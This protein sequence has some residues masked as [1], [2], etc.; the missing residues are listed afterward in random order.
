MPAQ[1]APDTNATF[2]ERRTRISPS[3]HTSDDTTHTREARSPATPADFRRPASGL[4]TLTEAKTRRYPEAIIHCNQGG[5]M[6][7]LVGY[8][9]A[10]GSTTGIAERIGAKFEQEGLSATVCPVS[11]IGAVNDYDAVVLGSAIHNQRWLPEAAALVRRESSTLAAVPV[12][13]FSV[14]S[15]GAQTSVFTPVVDRVIRKMSKETKEMAEFRGLLHARGHH[16]FAGAI[17]PGYY[18]LIGRL[19]MKLFGGRYGDHRDWAEVDAWAE[20]IAL[21]LRT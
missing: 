7:V 21:E 13:L 8:A 14:S 19:F 10:H 9:T 11:Q 4:L 18:P 2:S 5:A 17:E 20:G 3:A 15:V 12:W 16:G 1:K 6:K